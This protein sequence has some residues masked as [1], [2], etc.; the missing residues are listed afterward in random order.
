MGQGA[1]GQAPLRCLL[2]APQSEGCGPRRETPAGGATTPYGSAPR[3][4]R[5]NRARAETPYDL[6]WSPKTVVFH[7]LAPAPRAPRAG[8]PSGSEHGRGPGKGFR[9]RMGKIPPPNSGF[10]AP[11]AHVN[12]FLPG[13]SFLGNF[14]LRDPNRAARARQP[15]R[16]RL[17]TR[18]MHISLPATLRR[19]PC[20]ARAG[21]GNTGE[22]R[23]E[24][25]SGKLRLS[26]FI[27]PN[28][29]ET[30]RLRRPP[31][32]TDTSRLCAQRRAP[33]LHVSTAPGPLCSTY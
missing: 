31:F 11:Y 29:C 14:R 24:S 18:L 26:P 9:G 32:R 6:L 8:H 33:A 19:V 7:A 25:F 22:L 4:A 12:N 16:L 20:G 27:P 2:P 17:A 15:L 13:T 23:Q 30:A 10:R 21:P 1:V 5:G 28:A 3:V